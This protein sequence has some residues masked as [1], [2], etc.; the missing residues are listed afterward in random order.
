MLVLSLIAMDHSLDVVHLLLVSNLGIFVTVIFS[1]TIQ[2][3][4]AEMLE[5]V[6]VVSMLL[7]RY[8]LPLLVSACVSLTWLGHD[9]LL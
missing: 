9:V 2:C 4:V 7:L 8:L 1:L 5:Q 3:V 6:L